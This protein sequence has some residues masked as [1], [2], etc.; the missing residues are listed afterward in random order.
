MLGQHP[1]VDLGG[2]HQKEKNVVGL[3]FAGCTWKVYRLVLGDSTRFFFGRIKDKAAHDTPSLESRFL[4]SHGISTLIS[5]GLRF[6]DPD[7]SPSSPTT[8]SLISKLYV[9]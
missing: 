1:G 9:N 8:S 7:I 2:V 4:S 3:S 6:G 5:L